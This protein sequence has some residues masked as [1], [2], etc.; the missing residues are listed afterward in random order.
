M[1]PIIAPTTVRISIA[2]SYLGTTWA[3]VMHA[4]YVGGATAAEAATA[5]TNAWIDDLLPALDSNVTA[6]SFN[7]VDLGTELGISGPTPGVTGTL[8][9]GSAGAGSPANTAYL[10]S[11]EALGTRKQ[12]NGRM[13]LVG[14]PEAATDEA[15]VVDDD[16]LDGLQDRADDFFADSAASGDAT[17]AVLSKSTGDDYEGRTVTGITVSN[18]V[19]TQRRRLRR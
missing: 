4:R 18:R 8:T 17:L 14:V 3:N 13:Y 9:G 19:A 12:R 2:G 15:G 16:F 1:A 5:V 10:L 6:E 11:L 7:Y